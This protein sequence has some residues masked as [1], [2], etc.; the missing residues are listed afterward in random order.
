MTTCFPTRQT[1]INW[2]KAMWWVSTDGRAA[3]SGTG[4]PVLE[5]SCQLIFLLHAVA[6]HMWWVYNI[7]TKRCARCNNAD[8][9]RPDDTDDSLVKNI[10]VSGH[11]KSC[12]SGLRVNPLW[13][14]GRQ[15][16][17]MC[18]CY[19]LKRQTIN[20]TKKASKLQGQLVYAILRFMVQL[21][22]L[23]SEL[24]DQ[25]VAPPA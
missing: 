12:C 17:H 24:E 6:C 8:D 1:V 19:E 25:Q 14:Q 18:V 23:Y 3:D 11:T 10:I 21:Q 22:W 20:A 13:E 5:C 9:K 4:G 2:Y 15:C 7:H 16:T